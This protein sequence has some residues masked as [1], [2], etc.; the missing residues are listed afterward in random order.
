MLHLQDS[1]CQG[2]LVWPA[3]VVAV[4]SSESNLLCVSQTHTSQYLLLLTEKH[5]SQM[6]HTLRKYILA[7]CVDKDG[8]WH[9]YLAPSHPSSSTFW[10]GGSPP[11]SHT[12]SVSLIH[13][14]IVSSLE[15]AFP[16]SWHTPAIS[17][18]FITGPARRHWIT[19]CLIFKNNITYRTE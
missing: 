11:P 19:T 8:Q 9:K 2:Q 14:D 5:R 18:L 12:R 4:L 6:T 1:E 16:Y 10:V 7:G 17:E 13:S 15:T 3:W